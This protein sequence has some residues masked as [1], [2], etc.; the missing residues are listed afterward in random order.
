MRRASRRGG[1]QHGGGSAAPAQGDDTYAPQNLPPPSDAVL[2]LIRAGDTLA[3]ARMYK[4]E[5][6]LGLLESKRV[7]TWYATHAA[8]G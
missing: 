6:D 8:G 7:V 1:R 3:A 5:T 4:D 2:A